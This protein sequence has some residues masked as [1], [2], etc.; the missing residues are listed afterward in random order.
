MALLTLPTGETAATGTGPWRGL[1]S[2]LEHASVL[3]AA[4]VWILVMTRNS[5]GHVGW[6]LTGG[7][8]SLLP[9]LAFVRI[10]RVGRGVALA[11]G[12]SIVGGIVALSLTAPGWSRAPWFGDQA[13]GLVCFLVALNYATTHRR[14]LAL[15]GTV[16]AAGVWEFGLALLPWWGHGDPAVM[17]V[18]TFY[19][20]NQFGAFMLGTGLCGAGL[21][22]LGRS[23]IRLAGLV[24]AA[25]AAVGVWL[26]ISRANIALFAVG[27]L[28]L[29]FY[30]WRSTPRR[31]ALIRW[32][33]IPALAA[34]ILALLVSHL[35]FPHAAYHVAASAVGKSSVNSL[36]INGSARILF[37]RAALLSWLGSPLI[38]Y[39]FG[40]FF[41]L[42]VNHMPLGY[43]LSPYVHDA[44]AEALVSG[45]IVFAAPALAG[46]V[47]LGR[48]FLSV[49]RDRE[50]ALARDA[51]ALRLTGAI[52]AIA[53]FGHSAF[54]FD[55][56]FPA[57]AALAGVVAALA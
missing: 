36:S 42:S 39:G 45:G 12:G 57:L 11:V 49:L 55:W 16:V 13:Y 54:D 7:A 47:Y 31:G 50:P 26:S 22:V 40:S 21:Y 9:A 3:F 30:A 32:A 23:P 51:R 34:A 33:L 43:V 53:L 17:M 56:H 25:I 41:A 10:A 35:L 27:W 8:L 24:V 18:G 48:R 6:S 46:L 2:W 44:F 28:V 38:G 5:G 29:G 15:A 20:H 14:R 52:T 1:R 19:W 4:A 37:T